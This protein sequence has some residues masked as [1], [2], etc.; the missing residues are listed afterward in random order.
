MS[1]Q[2]HK[3]PENANDSKNTRMD[4]RAA[5]RTGDWRADILAHMSRYDRI[6]S[7]M[8]EESK[9]LGRPLRILD[10]GCGEMW[11]LRVLFHSHADVKASVI[12]DYVG[13]DIE[14][15]EMDFMTPEMRERIGVRRVVQD[16]TLKPTMPVRNSSIDFAFSTECIEHMKPKFVPAWLDGVD[17]A[18]R[19]GGLLFFSTP[20]SDGSNDKLPLDHVY[21]WGYEELKQ[22]LEF[23]WDLQHHYGTFIKLPAF[24]KANREQGLVPE[25]LVEAYERRFGRHWLRNMLATS[26]PEVANNVSWTLRKP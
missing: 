20:N 22:E 12:S 9:R 7:L 23:R 25:A 24:R 10:V 16:L 18:V 15:W 21:E 17:K 26:Y 6:A 19:K 4:I 13:V 1:S 5:G 2:R 8:I 11:P 14:P 3:L